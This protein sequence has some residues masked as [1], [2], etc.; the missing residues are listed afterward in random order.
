MRFMQFSIFHE[1]VCYLGKK[2]VEELRIQVQSY[3][4][5]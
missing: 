2:A 4:G 5:Q 1:S 3:G